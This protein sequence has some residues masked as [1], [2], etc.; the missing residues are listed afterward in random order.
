MLFEE[1][2]NYSV[3]AKLE[4]SNISA[5]LSFE[6]GCIKILY[7]DPDSPLYQMEEIY[8]KDS[9]RFQGNFTR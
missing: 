7:N 1:N 8:T 5:N 2:T 6:G 4:E 3:E 9:F